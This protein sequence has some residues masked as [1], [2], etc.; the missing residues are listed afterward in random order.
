MSKVKYENSKAEAYLS[1]GSIIKIGWIYFAI[2]LLLFVVII[3]D[4]ILLKKNKYL[5]TLLYILKLIF[6]GTE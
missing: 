5:P 2:S 1:I 3:V 4:I 6:V